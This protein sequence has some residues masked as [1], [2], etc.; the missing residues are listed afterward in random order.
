MGGQGALRCVQTQI[1]VQAL[2]AERCLGALHRSDLVRHIDDI[3]Q[4]LHC[5]GHLF[6]LIFV[7]ADHARR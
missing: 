7:Q 6:Q 2:V 4:R 1:Q 5:S 3:E